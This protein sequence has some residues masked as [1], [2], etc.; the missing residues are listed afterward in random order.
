MA[1]PKGQSACQAAPANTASTTPNF[2]NPV[3]SGAMSS[4][5]TSAMVAVTVPCQQCPPTQ[6]CGAGGAGSSGG[7]GGAG[8]SPQ[9]PHWLPQYSS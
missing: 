6:C 3:S 2:G 9:G 1:A 4:G 5:G 8:G 7:A